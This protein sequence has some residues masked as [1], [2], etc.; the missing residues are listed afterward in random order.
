[1]Y[2]IKYT[3]YKKKTQTLYV[4]IDLYFG[5]HQFLYNEPILRNLWVLRPSQRQGLLGYD[6]TLYVVTTQ[7]SIWDTC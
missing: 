5:M 7:A 4:L 1:M 2:F 6:T 3:P